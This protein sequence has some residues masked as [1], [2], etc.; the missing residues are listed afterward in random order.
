MNIIVIEILSLVLFIAGAAYAPFIGIGIAIIGVILFTI[1]IL[2]GVACITNGTNK[3]ELIYV[4]DLPSVPEDYS[5]LEIPEKVITA[6]NGETVKVPAKTIDIGEVVFTDDKSKV[7]I[8]EVKKHWKCFYMKENI[9]YVY[10]QKG[11]N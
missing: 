2:I 1:S 7:G 10:A 8:Y 3:E 6:K 9:T 5:E 11:A 4:V